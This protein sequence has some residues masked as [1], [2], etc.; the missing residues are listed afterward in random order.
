M[1]K[2]KKTRFGYESKKTPYLRFSQ[3]Y[4]GVKI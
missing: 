3:Q 1:Y 2:P 4:Y